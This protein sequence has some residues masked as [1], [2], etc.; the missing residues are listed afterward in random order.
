MSL[1][2]FREAVAASSQR[3]KAGEKP[4]TVECPKCHQPRG[5]AL[6]AIGDAPPMTTAYCAICSFSWVVT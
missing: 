5:I 3:I 6:T 1:S 2:M 4:D